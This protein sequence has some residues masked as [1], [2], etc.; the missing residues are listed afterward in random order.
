M[1]KKGNS[2][3]GYLVAGMLLG[4]LGFAQAAKVSKDPKVLP[5]YNQMLQKGSLS[6]KASSTPSEKP[7]AQG[8]AIVVMKENLSAS[9]ASSVLSQ[10]SIKVL[11]AYKNFKSSY[12]LVSGNTSTEEL[13]AQL[14]KNP[15]VKSVSPNY[16]RMIFA[17]T[18]NDPGFVQNLLWGLHNTGQNVNGT[19]GT[20]DADI[21][22][23]EAWDTSTG[24]SDVVVAVFDTGVDYTHED[25][26]ANMWVNSAEANG[27]LGVDDDGNG[28]TDDVYGYDF[29][30]WTDGSNDPDPMD[31]MG[32]G[33]HVSGTIGAKGDNGIG[34]TGVN[35]NVKI[36]AL[37]VFRPSMEAYDSDILEAVDYVLTMKNNGVNVVA[38]NASYGGGCGTDFQN[39]PMN[40][41]IK[42][43]GDAGIVFAAAAGNENNNNDATPS[44]PASYDASNL[45]AVA[46][47]DQDDNLAYFSN[48][49]ATSV[50][51]AAPG[52]NILSTLPSFAMPDNNIFSDNVESSEGNWTASGTWAITTEEANSPTHAW[53]DSPDANYTNNAN[54]SLTYSS[55]IDLSGYTGQNIGLGACLK[56]D[57]EEGYDYLYIEASDDSGSSW[58]T[59][60]SITGTQGTWGCGGVVIPENMKTANFRMR[61]RLV[62]DGS[63]VYDGVYI[64]DIAIGA[65]NPSD[66]YAYWAGTSM[67]TP[68]VTGAA[69]LMAAAFPAESVAE[70]IDRILNGADPLTSLNGKVVTDG[71]LNI[72]N[73]IN[74]SAV[75]HDPVAQ[76]DT[77]TVAEDSSV[78]IDVLSN[79]SDVDGDTLSISTVG[80][81]GHGTAVISGTQI[82]YT[83]TADYNGPDSFTYTISD[84]NGGTATATVSVTVTAVNDAPVAQN[85]TA[86][87]AEDSSVN[88]DVLSNDSD[89]D[90][91]TLSISTVGSPGH[92]TAVISGTQIHYIPTADY[93]GSDSFT[94]TISDGNGG[95][96]TATVSVTVTAAGG[97]GGGGGG[98]CSYNPHNKGFDAMMLFMMMLS[99][100]YPLKRKYL[101]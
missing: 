53:S 35:W 12:M 77:A 41:A 10:N 46:A 13:V 30:G 38:I 87:V 55:D 4:T 47:T 86:T 20:D 21:D 85:D 39:D 79:D 36:M 33:T 15:D 67:A 101:S 52:T 71:R 96:A 60:G 74:L 43:L 82:H 6:A 93:N 50:D 80:S 68:H 51:I 32:H 27:T 59:L 1:F 69:A 92:G 54:T 23:P 34:I 17:T 3:T 83:P 2:F 24:S 9:E 70:R 42:S 29:A 5:E 89:V 49:G 56:F 100:F 88:I 14:K 98:G 72:A 81:P 40:T 11:K 16:R 22:A 44:C 26:S 97:N 61:L 99:L 45:I 91:D 64:D 25:L 95:T 65:I 58:T 57:I 76:N 31:I 63:V 84:G 75:N 62:T 28:Y 66:S 48:Y 8:E 18:P 90:G 73:S 94:Y 37:K 19:S 7:Y 78:N